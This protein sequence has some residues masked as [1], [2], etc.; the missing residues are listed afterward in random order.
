MS[1]MERVEKL[2][3][4]RLVRAGPASNSPGIISGC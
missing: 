3:Q 1:L 4:K 2:E